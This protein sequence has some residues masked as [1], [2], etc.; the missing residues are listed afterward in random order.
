[1]AAVRAIA[2]TFQSVQTDLRAG[3]PLADAAF[4]AAV[5]LTEGLPRQRYRSGADRATGPVFDPLPLALAAQ[6][7]LGPDRRRA[8]GA[9][10]HGGARRSG[11]RIARG[12][13]HHRHR[14][15]P[16]AG[17]PPAAG[18]AGALRVLAGDAFALLGVA[19]PA[20][21]YVI[22]NP[23]FGSLQPMRDQFRAT[24]T[25]AGAP[26]TTSGSTM[27]AVKRPAPAPPRW[28]AVFILAAEHPR[29]H[30]LERPD[31]GSRY[32]FNSWPTTSRSRR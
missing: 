29:D 8:H 12:R 4:R 30:A 13:G 23:P 27:R 20:Y 31:G 5:A 9:G 15:R 19:E 1:M 32:L 17:R 2:P 3:R 21:D 22:A 28:R 14:T 25:V 11:V 10:T 16:G 24:V 26:F 18:A 6:A 7:L